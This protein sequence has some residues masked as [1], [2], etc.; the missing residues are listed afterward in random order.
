M[1]GSL[2]ADISRLGPDNA[3]SDVV[4]STADGHRRSAN[5][6]IL[7]ARSTVL[8]KMLSSDMLEGK[9]P[10]GQHAVQ[11]KDTSADALDR[12]LKWCY[13]DSTS[14]SLDLAATVELLVAADYL[15]IPGL[16]ARCAQRLSKLL[17]PENF[18]EALELCTAIC[19]PEL[20]RQLASYAARGA[21]GAAAPS[22]LGVLPTELRP[23]AAEARVALL[24]RELRQLRER[25]SMVPA[26]RPAVV[27]WR[28]ALSLEEQRGFVYQALES[29]EAGIIIPALLHG[30]RDKAPALF[31]EASQQH[32]E[33]LDAEVRSRYEEAAF[34]DE[35]KVAQ[36]RTGLE[37]LL[38]ETKA[39][40]AAWREQ[41]AA[42]T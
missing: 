34:E 32:W 3:F 24:E 35:A 30:L 10:S 41:T 37:Q 2:L 21:V 33:S 7:A 16:L 18:P 19:S 23:L 42:S 1:A 40:L 13:T 4:I 29:G 38:D 8:Q 26:P 25:L 20:L 11:L 14:A 22:L 31:R 39:E 6:A 5:S 28:Q 12:V 17:T 27:F 15:E 9:Q 36:S